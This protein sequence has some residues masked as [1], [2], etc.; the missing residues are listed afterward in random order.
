M[1]AA[2]S[3]LA[4]VI[5][6][7]SVSPHADPSLRRYSKRKRGAERG[8]Q[9]RR[10]LCAERSSAQA[11]RKRLAQCIEGNASLTIE[12]DGNEGKEAWLV[13]LDS[14]KSPVAQRAVRIGQE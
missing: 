9:H 8:L 12:D 6:S 3:A 4:R 11:I 1:Y 14:Q 13:V 7:A 5:R 2:S 10:I